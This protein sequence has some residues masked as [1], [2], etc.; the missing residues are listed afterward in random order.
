MDH[1]MASYGGPADDIDKSRLERAK[2]LR[3]ALRR[4]HDEGVKVLRGWRDASLRS[5]QL[6][7][8]V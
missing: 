1:V 3:D 6:E 5:L 7:R 4:G 8:F 2:R